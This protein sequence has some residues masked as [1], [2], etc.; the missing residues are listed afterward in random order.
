LETTA[1][2][3]Y[4]LRGKDLSGYDEPALD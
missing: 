2:T 1:N 3:V 4:A